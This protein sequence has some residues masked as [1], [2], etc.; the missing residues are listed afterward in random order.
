MEEWRICPECLGFSTFYPVPSCLHSATVHSTSLDCLHSQYSHGLRTGLT[1]VFHVS[2]V[3]VWLCD[4]CLDLHAYTCGEEKLMS[5]IFNYP[6]PYL[7]IETQPLWSWSSLIRLSSKVQALS[8]PLGQCLHLSSWLPYSIWPLHGYWG[9]ESTLHVCRA[10][11]L[12][13]SQPPRTGL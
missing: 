3:F 5:D 7:F 6:P 2:Y 9:P 12:S 4:V 11:T 13:S 8:P 1:S 10:S